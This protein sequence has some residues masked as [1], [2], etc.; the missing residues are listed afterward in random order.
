MAEL[1][2]HES[3]STDLVARYGGE[4][5]VVILTGADLEAAMALG[6]RIRESVEHAEWDHEPLTVSVGVASTSGSDDAD[7]LVQLADA[8][9]YR[10]KAAG[11]NLT[12]AA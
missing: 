8:A 1:I 9:M 4:E 12:V 2:S 3:R 6:E 5:F 11:R 7:E 10:A